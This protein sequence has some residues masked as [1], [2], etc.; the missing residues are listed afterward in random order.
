MDLAEGQLCDLQL[1]V[2]DVAQRS[3][4]TTASAK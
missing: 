4:T 3:P 2:G 1:G